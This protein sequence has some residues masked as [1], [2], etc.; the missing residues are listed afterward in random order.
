MIVGILKLRGGGGGEVR[1]VR[2]IEAW[3]RGVRG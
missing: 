1:G 2:G 3:G